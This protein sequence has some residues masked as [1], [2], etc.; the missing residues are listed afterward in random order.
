MKRFVENKIPLMITYV[1]HLFFVVVFLCVGSRKAHAQLKH[2]V[3]KKAII[4]NNL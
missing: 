1:E 4:V 3:A 2:V